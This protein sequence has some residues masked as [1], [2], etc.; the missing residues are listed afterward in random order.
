MSKIKGKMFLVFSVIFVVLLSFDQYT[1]YL[2][3]EYL[4]GGNDIILIDGVLELQYLENRGAAFGL[5]QNQKFFILFVG[6]IF[7]AILLFVLFKLP[8]HKKYNK[9]Y[10]L[11]AAMTAG[12]IGNMIDRIRFDFVVDFIYFSLIDFPIFN[13]ADIYITLSVIVLAIIV[14]FVYKEEDFEFLSFKQKKYRELK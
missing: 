13:V 8:E 11:A 3:I 2:A 9:L 5:L 1:K 7:L 10:Y 6:L 14:L 12:A 4:K